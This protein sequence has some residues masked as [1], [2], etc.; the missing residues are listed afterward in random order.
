MTIHKA[1]GNLIDFY[2][3]QFYNQGDTKYDS[4]NGLFTE[5][6]SVFS[7]TSV[8]EIIKRGIPSNKIVIGKP[9]TPGDAANT[10]Y[11]RSDDLGQWVATGYQSLKWYAGIM[12]WQ[13]V[14]DADG[15]AIKNSAGFL[16]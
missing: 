12:Y 16:K 3:V 2:N 8:T 14:S 1:V 5:S 6:G 7:G 4:Y 9:V 11:V 15:S 10:G 13:Y